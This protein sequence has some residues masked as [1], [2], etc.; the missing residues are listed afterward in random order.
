ML[1]GNNDNGL[2]LGHSITSMNMNVI[3]NE[4][5]NSHNSIVITDYKEEKNPYRFVVKISDV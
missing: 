4:L 5:I 2:Y 3:F 1:Q